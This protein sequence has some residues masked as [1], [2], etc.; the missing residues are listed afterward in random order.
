MSVVRADGLLSR[1]AAQKSPIEVA[2]LAVLD[3][4]Q[5]FDRKNSRAGWLL[6]GA[7]CSSR[8]NSGSSRLFSS[9]HHHVDIRV[10]LSNHSPGVPKRYSPAVRKNGTFHLTAAEVSAH[11]NL[12]PKTS[13]SRMSVRSG[14]PA[15]C[16]AEWTAKRGPG[17]NDP[18]KNHE[19][20]PVVQVGHPLCSL[21]C[22]HSEFRFAFPKRS[23]QADKLSSGA[24]H[25]HAVSPHQ[26]GATPFRPR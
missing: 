14:I 22:R 24:R 8:Q 15:S 16:C 21:Q 23:S 2:E 7:S 18:F 3:A 11:G 20:R 9:A 1:L 13:P 10:L 4:S 25:D 12:D 17:M 5:P 19:P 26:A 6:R